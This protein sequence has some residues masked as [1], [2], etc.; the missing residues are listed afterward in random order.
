[1]GRS[2]RNRNKQKLEKQQQKQSQRSSSYHTNQDHAEGGSG[3]KYVEMITKSG[4]F[5]ME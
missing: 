5:K 2:K 3:D 1:M 4:N